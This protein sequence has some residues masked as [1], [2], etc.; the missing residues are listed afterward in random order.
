M[1]GYMRSFG[2]L[3]KAAPAI[4]GTFLREEEANAERFGLCG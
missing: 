4:D 2:C 3:F 1:V